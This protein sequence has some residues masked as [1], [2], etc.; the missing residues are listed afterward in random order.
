MT[1]PITAAELPALLTIAGK[2]WNRGWY[3]AAKHV[4]RSGC[5]RWEI[6]TAS[7][8][9]RT[10]RLFD[11]SANDIDAYTVHARPTAA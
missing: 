2:E 3:R 9:G 11:Y 1:K 5:A 6:Q 4:W 7:E 8:T 10:F